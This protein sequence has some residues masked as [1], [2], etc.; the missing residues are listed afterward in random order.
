MN[1]N[2]LRAAVAAT[3]LIASVTL[4]TAGAGTSVAL[5]QQRPRAAALVFGGPCG[6]ATACAHAGARAGR[7]NAARA[8]HRAVASPTRSRA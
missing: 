4:A 7:A 2:K 5:G 6:S 8:T 1:T 3:T